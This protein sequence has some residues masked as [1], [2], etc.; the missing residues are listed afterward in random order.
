MSLAEIVAGLWIAV[1]AWLV[2]LLARYD[3]T[4]RHGE[5]RHG[6]IA[7]WKAAEA[8]HKD[9]DSVPPPAA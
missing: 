9:T 1:L 6:R 5:F 8:R 4:F 7:S 2:Y 3:V